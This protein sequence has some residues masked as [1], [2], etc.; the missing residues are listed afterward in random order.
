M[1]ETI[2][3]GDARDV[4]RALPDVSFEAIITDP[5]WPNALPGLAVG[6]TD[7]A[8]LFASVA[9]EFPRLLK[10]GGR[11]VVTLGR[12]SDPRFLTGVPGVLPFLASCFLEYACPNHNGRLLYTND[13]AYVFGQYPESKPGHHVLPGKAMATRTEARFLNHPC[14]R[15][16]AHVQWLVRFL[17]GNG[18]VL[19]PF[20]GSGTTAVACAAHGVD[21]TTIEARPEWN[22]LAAQRLLGVTRNMFVREPQHQEVTALTTCQGDEAR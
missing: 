21:C 2:L 16:L 18:P 12:D 8:A 6:E 13:V 9:S 7:P 1:S 11:V 5:V 22:A 19:D 14:P 10:P 4:V 20:G 15:P 3:T 17:A